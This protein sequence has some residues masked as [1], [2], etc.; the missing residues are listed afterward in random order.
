MDIDGGAPGSFIKRPDV[1]LFFVNA[2]NSYSQIRKLVSS[3]STLV[4]VVVIDLSASEDL[5]VA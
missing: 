1:P 2:S 5:D 4:E 3:A